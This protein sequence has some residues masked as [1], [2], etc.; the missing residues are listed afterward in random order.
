MKGSHLRV[1]C[2]ISIMLAG[3]Q[4][5]LVKLA[6]GR[7]Q[8]AQAAKLCG[9]CCD[10]ARKQNDVG[11][12]ALTLGVLGRIA[13]WQGDPELARQQ[14]LECLVL[15]GDSFSTHLSRLTAM[16]GKLAEA[17][18]DLTQAAAYHAESLERYRA[19]EDCIGVAWAQ[20]NLGYVKLVQGERTAAAHLL[21]AS[22]AGL[23]QAEGGHDARTSYVA[24]S[25]LSAAA[26]LI[27]QQGEVSSAA[28]LWG[29]A[30]LLQER[31]PPSAL[32]YECQPEDRPRITAAYTRL[33]TG[34]HEPDWVSGRAHPLDEALA[35]ALHLIQHHRERL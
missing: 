4:Y 2:G 13:Y 25:C 20:R 6:M 12:I 16:L 14:H 8:L 33:A 9:E 15:I 26:K 35:K 1:T 23:L 32:W 24:V 17:A 31:F 18:G 19:N 28:L 34:A 22:L 30:E 21:C 3:A 11:L 27:E 29:A 10:M 5:S 7:G